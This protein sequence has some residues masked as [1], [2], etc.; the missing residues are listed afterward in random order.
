MSSLKALQTRKVASKTHLLVYKIKEA[1][2]WLKNN[3]YEIYMMWIPS[4]ERIRVNKWADQL[5]VLWNAPVR[6]SDFF[7]CPG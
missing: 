1:C 6:P 5:V 2:W 3:G 7:L 4:H